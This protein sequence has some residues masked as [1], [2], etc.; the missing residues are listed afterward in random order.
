MVLTAIVNK[1]HFVS[2][3]IENQSFGYKVIINHGFYL[4]TQ[5]SFFTGFAA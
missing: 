1:Y 2:K 5:A 4:V 3:L